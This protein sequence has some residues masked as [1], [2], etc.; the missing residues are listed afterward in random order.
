[1][2][3][4]GFEKCW[5][6]NWDGEGGETG[7]S[8]PPILLR[9][10]RWWSDE[11]QAA[12]LAVEKPEEVDARVELEKDADEKVI[13]I[14][15]DELMIET[16]TVDPS[17]IGNPGGAAAAAVEKEGKQVRVPARGKQRAPKKRS[18]V[19]LFAVAPP[20]D[21]L[22]DDA[23][24]GDG[25]EER[26]EDGEDGEER[27][28][29]EDRELGAG[30]K[31]GGES[32]EA[33]RKRTVLDMKDDEKK[34][35]KARKKIKEKIGKKTK[36]KKLKVEICAAK[37][38][39]IGNFKMSSP[40][41]ISHILQN[42]LHD[43]KLRKIQRNLVDGQKKSVTA[44]SLPKKHK[45]KLIQ[46]S[47]LISR[48]QKE[49][50][51]MFPLHS[52]LKNRKGGTSVKKGKTISDAQGGNF[53]KLCCKSAKRV[54]FSG[55]DDILGL[56]KRCSTMQLPHLQ[57]LC[58]IFSDVLAASSAM[59]NLS[60]GDKC[61]PPIEGAQV[62]NARDKDLARS[63][64]EMTD[65]TVSEEKQLSGSYDHAIPHSFTDP[66]KR[67]S[68]ETKRSP[69]S[70]S[71]DLNHAVQDISELS[72]FSLSSTTSPTHAYSG[73]PKVLNP[74]HEA[75]SICDAGTHGEESSQMM[76]SAIRNLHGPIEKCVPRSTATNSLTLTRNSILRHS[77]FCLE[78]S[79]E[80]SKEQHLRCVDPTM[81][82]CSH[83]PGFQP[84]HHHSPKDL[85]SSISSSVS[86]KE[87]DE[88]RLMSDLMSTCREKSVDKDF[89]GLPLNSQGELMQLHSNTK[90]VYSDFYK[91]QNSVR[92]SVCSFPVPNCV[93]PKSSQVKLKEKFPC[94][95]LYQKDPLSW[96]LEQY[97]PA[98]KVVTSG[99][100][101]TDLQ[102]FEI[103][104]IQ[105][106]ENQDFDQITH[107]DTN[108]MEVSCCGCMECNKTENYIDGVHFHAEKNLDSRFQPVIRPTMRL[109]G[110][111]VTV[112]RS[113]E[114]CLGF[115][116]G[117]RWSDN[118]LVTQ[119][120]PSITVSGKPFMKIWPRGEPVEHAEYVS[121]KENLFKSLEVPSSVYCMPATE[122]SS[123]PM[124]LDFQP[125]WLSRSSDIG[126]NG[127]NAE[128]FFNSIPQ[129][130]LKKTTNS[131]VNC[132]SGTQH[133]KMGHQQPVVGP[134]P[135]NA[136]Q[137]MLLNSPHCK[138]SQSVPYKA[139][140]YLVQLLWFTI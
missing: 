96:S 57:N 100:G 112:G 79:S 116:D 46:T 55:K 135:Q 134:Y 73:D 56:K 103:M 54:S 80:A 125:Q 117:K 61:P 74:I 140:A 99:M 102:G 82:F 34:Q 49:V 77:P 92:N 78:K 23:N 95:S 121:S 40:V 19:E 107:C 83:R 85:I 105:N 123:N 33:L 47:K 104:E 89:I 136:S 26:E 64:V 28:Q 131:A 91:K 68:P 132:N 4:V 25:R 2:R 108:Q 115:N 48:N 52:I 24:G 111:N 32:W 87:F 70:E 128:L 138:H 62:V 53:I 109:M 7:R 39:K 130:L 10:F 31:C 42:K 36:K 137:H 88:S 18:I 124:Q 93:E 44:K 1:M 129:Q 119:N 94:A 58:K 120:C 65:G 139:I 13:S 30:D 98:G 38:E 5:P 90:F 17:V 50:T 43:K 11:L 113:N 20:V 81:D 15:N 67:K 84:V 59:D 110:K 8:L 12:R 122:F 27:D 37:K 41:D 133:V 3:S 75:G 101:F 106:R 126:S 114:E 51:R 29:E 45:F 16:P 66:S 6:F 97:Y 14:P 21:T 69:L 22:E 118:E 127:Y 72:C 76:S 60:K 35:E 9:K 71:V 86:S 63:D